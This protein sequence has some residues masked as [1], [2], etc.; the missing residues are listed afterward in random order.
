MRLV[1]CVSLWLR[2][3]SASI[4]SRDAQRAERINSW[5]V[6]VVIDA[7][8]RA[9]SRRHQRE[10]AKMAP[11]RLPSTT[12]NSRWENAHGQWLRVNLT[13]DTRWLD[14]RRNPALGAATSALGAAWP[15]ITE[16]IRRLAGS[17]RP[18]CC[19]RRGLSSLELPGLLSGRPPCPFDG[20]ICRACIMLLAYCQATAE[21][22]AL[23][24]MHPGRSLGRR[25]A[26]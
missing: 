26:D 23:P 3:K 10:G 16:Q 18:S 11:Y 19:F 25:Y 9:L 1:R 22:P 5:V 17:M 12:R 6:V 20:E 8:C 14:S 7:P 21:F 15:A 4:L 2:G 13:L 24:S